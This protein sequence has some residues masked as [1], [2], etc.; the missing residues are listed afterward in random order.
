MRKHKIKKWLI[1]YDIEVGIAIVMT[2]LILTTTVSYFVAKG[3]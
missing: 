1:T 2:L 3:F